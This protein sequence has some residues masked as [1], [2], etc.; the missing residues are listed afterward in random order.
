MRGTGAAPPPRHKRRGGATAPPRPRGGAAPPQPADG[1]LRG[2]RPPPQTARRRLVRRP[3][4]NW[5]CD[6]ALCTPRRPTARAVAWL[7]SRAPPAVAVAAAALSASARALSSDSTSP[8]PARAPPPPCRSSAGSP[9]LRASKILRS[10]PALAC[11][12]SRR[13][14]PRASP[15]ARTARKSH[16]RVSG[17]VI[18]IPPATVGITRGERRPFSSWPRPGSRLADKK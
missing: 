18:R 1:Q 10:K 9:A 16:V 13:E 12:A 17:V 4:P 6:E 3:I 15:A 8:Q 7:P 11:D 14:A 2:L 5:R